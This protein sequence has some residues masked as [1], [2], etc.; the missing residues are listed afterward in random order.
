MLF[1][2]S[3][4][5]FYQWP[6][7]FVV[8]SQKKAVS[9]AEIS[10]LSHIIYVT[11]F[12][13]AWNWISTALIPTVCRS[14]RVTAVSAYT[15][16]TNLSAGPLLQV[17]IFK[18]KLKIKIHS[19]HQHTSDNN[20]NSLGPSQLVDETYLND[21]ETV[22]TLPWND[23]EETRPPTPTLLDTVEQVDILPTSEKKKSLK[24]I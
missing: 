1:L 16:T 6:L 17:I 20:H 3:I 8:S 19:N 12:P 11:L 2:Q 22:T 15:Y 21:D 23:T 7:F 5:L 18:F 9:I 24:Y 13:T 14:V 4:C 10:S